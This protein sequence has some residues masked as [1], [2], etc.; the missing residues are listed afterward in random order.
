[1]RHPDH[2]GACNAHYGRGDVPEDK[3]LLRAVRGQLLVADAELAVGVAHR[4]HDGVTHVQRPALRP[5]AADY[6]GE[7]GAVVH[8]PG[9]GGGAREQ[10]LGS[11]VQRPLL[12]LVVPG[13]RRLR[14]E[15]VLAGRHCAVWSGVACHA[16]AVV[17]Q[18]ALFACHGKVGTRANRHDR[19]GYGYVDGRDGVQKVGKRVAAFVG[20]ASVDNGSTDGQSHR[21]L[22]CLG[23]MVAPRTIPQHLVQW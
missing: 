14:P 23:I 16:D 20:D 18:L 19:L 15:S 4:L 8:V 9:P 13:R 22:D 5:A 10:R 3:L 1:M 2:H 17:A 11:R 7:R 12:R 6:P 21:M